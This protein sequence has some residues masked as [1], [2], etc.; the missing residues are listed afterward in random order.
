MLFVT[1][2]QYPDIMILTSYK[3]YEG[4]LSMSWSPEPI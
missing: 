2:C 1:Y 3:L 4:L